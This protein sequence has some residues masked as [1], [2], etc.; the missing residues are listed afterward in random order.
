[1]KL[2]LD[3]GALIALERNDRMTW[4][5]LKSALVSGEVPITHGGVI[6]QAW[7]GRGPR[8]ALLGLA[9][10]GVDVRAIDAD[11]GKRSGEL[12][13]RAKKSDVIDAALVLLSTDGDVV[14][15][16][17]VKDLHA[18]ARAAGRM[19]DLVQV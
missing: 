13:Q 18:L 12:L 8:A 3:A 4:R 7:R 16:S 6:G 14:I 19:I 11:L 9:L 5:R 17:D 1:M 15:T 2:L 10:A